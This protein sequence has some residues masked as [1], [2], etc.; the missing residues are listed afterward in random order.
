MKSMRELT[1]DEASDVLREFGSRI[2]KQMLRSGIRSGVYEEFGTYIAP[3][4]GLNKE[5]GYYIKTK[6]FYE[7]IEKQLYDVPENDAISE[8]D[9]VFGG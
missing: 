3:N 4:D 2:G 7:W 6:A 9:K 5:P 1:I 8:Y